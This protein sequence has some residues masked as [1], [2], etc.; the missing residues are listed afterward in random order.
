MTGQGPT[1]GR[2]QGRNSDYKRTEFSSTGATRLSTLTL[3]IDLVVPTAC[4]TAYK[5]KSFSPKVVSVDF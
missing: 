4:Y 5:K 1:A 3:E 2:N